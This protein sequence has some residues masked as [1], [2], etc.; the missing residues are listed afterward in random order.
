MPR[1][2]GMESTMQFRLFED[3]K[4]GL[5]KRCKLLGQN[6]SFFIRNAIREALEK[7]DKVIVEKHVENLKEE[8]PQGDF[9]GTVSVPPEYKTEEASDENETRD[10]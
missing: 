6:P 2:F 7:L 9:I 1:K 10:L 8:I 3:E 4:Q 5:L